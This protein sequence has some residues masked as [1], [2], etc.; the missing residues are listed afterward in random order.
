MLKILLQKKDLTFQKHIEDL[1]A[2]HVVTNSIKEGD[3]IYIN[4]NKKEDSL[5][6][7]VNHEIESSS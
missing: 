5:Q 7:D 2:E 4:K 3:L 6:L 1:V